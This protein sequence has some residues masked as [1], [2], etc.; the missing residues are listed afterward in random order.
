MF[1]AH[2]APGDILDA[3]TSPVAVAYNVV[4]VVDIHSRQCCLEQ[5]KQVMDDRPLFEE[6]CKN[7]NKERKKQRLNKLMSYLSLTVV[8]SFLIFLNMQL[9]W[10]LFRALIIIGFVVF[11]GSC[12]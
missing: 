12:I 3:D 4:V 11:S 6:N 7:E 10:I 1:D 8:F 2:H 9:L 5:H